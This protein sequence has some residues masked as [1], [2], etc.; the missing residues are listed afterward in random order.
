[1]TPAAPTHETTA[2][3][4]AVLETLRPAMQADGGD[5]EL[6]S[7]ED[8][9]VSVRLKGMCLLCPSADMT[10]TRGIERT[11]RLHFPW[12]TAVRRVP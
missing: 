6:V 1:M 7:L 12:L 8:G 2:S 10:L 4:L 5:V 11:L 9:V 3:V